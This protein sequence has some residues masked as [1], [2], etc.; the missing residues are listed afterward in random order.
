MRKSP[1]SNEEASAAV[2]P[3][4]P[5][6]GAD[7]RQQLVDAERLGHVV[8]GAGIERFDLGPFLAFHRQAR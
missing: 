8:V 5:Q 1:S 7:A 4:A 2:A 3:L 6:R